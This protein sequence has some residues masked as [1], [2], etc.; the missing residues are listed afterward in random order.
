[1]ATDIEVPTPPDITNRGIPDS[2][3]S[4]MVTS[5]IDLR[6]EE[7]EQILRQNAWQEG[8][9]EWWHYSDLSEADIERVRELQLF[10]AFDFFWDS[11]AGRLRYVSPAIPD[12][13]DGHTEGT[14]SPAST[15]QSELADLGDIVSETITS[16]YLDWGDTTLS[17]PV[18]S[19][20]SFGQVPTR[21]QRKER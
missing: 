10:R 1:M 19:R 5:E 13:W 17:D 15:V 9:E 11:E 8:F 21:D 20:D 12:E 6:R 16:D 18:W 14:L 7:L 3:D 2:I 4:A